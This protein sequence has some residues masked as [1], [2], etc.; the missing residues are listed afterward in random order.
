MGTRAGAAAGA[1][2]EVAEVSCFLS[3]SSRASQT[4][5]PPKPQLQPAS[6]RVRRSP[7][8][9][10]RS[11]HYHSPNPLV[12]L[13]RRQLLPLSFRAAFTPLHLIGLIHYV[14]TQPRANNH[15]QASLGRKGLRAGPAEVLAY[16]VKDIVAPGHQVYLTISA[17]KF[18]F[19]SDLGAVREQP[20]SNRATSGAK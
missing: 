12:H 7:S 16:S 14:Y 20:G 18:S 17:T 2:K 13:S 9:S 6:H 19:G 5:H 11:F 8:P 10:L 1:T 15:H 3:Y 4:V